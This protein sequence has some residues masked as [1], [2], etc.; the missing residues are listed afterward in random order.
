MLELARVLWKHRGG[1]AAIGEACLVAG[2][3]HRALCRLDLVHRRFRAGPRPQLPGADQLRQPRLPLGDELSRHAQLH[4]NAPG[5]ASDAIRDIVP[6]AEIATHRPPQAGDYSFNNIGLPSFFM[7]SSTMPNALREE[8][9]YY[10]V[11]RLRRQHRLAHR[12]RH[13]GDRRPRHPAHRHEDL[14]AVGAAHRQCRGAA[15]RLG[16]DLRRIPGDHRRV[17]EGV[18]G[19]GR[20][21]AGACR[22]R[23]TEGRAWRGLVQAPVARRNAVLAELA[24]IL[25]PVNYTREP[26]FRHDPAYTVPPL[27]TLAVAAELPEFTDGARAALR[28]GRVDARAEPLLAAMEQARRLVEAAVS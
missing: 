24:R 1:A 28:A 27:P 25:V 4:A 19:N 21:C 26:R 5:L 22:D 14:P 20:P 8:K 12:E 15:V 18:A 17:R 16:G 10:D 11:S 7:L 3:F 6:D 2:P 9:G 13:A 23:G